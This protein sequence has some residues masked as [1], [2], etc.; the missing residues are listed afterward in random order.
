MLG[1]LRFSAKQAIEDYQS[2]WKNV[3]LQVSRRERLSPSRKKAKEASTRRLV[4]ALG[5]MLHNRQ[6]RTKSY[7]GHFLGDS[8]NDASFDEGSGEDENTLCS[9]EERCKT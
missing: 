1:R 7:V 6:E 8:W 3:A 2:I 9:D 5:K 4:T